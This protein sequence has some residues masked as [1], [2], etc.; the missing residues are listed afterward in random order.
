MEKFCFANGFF[1]L[2]NFSIEVTDTVEG[3]EGALGHLC[4]PIRDTVEEV[5]EGLKIILIVDKFTARNFK[6]LFVTNQVQITLYGYRGESILTQN[7]SLHQQTKTSLKALKVLSKFFVSPLPSNTGP[8]LKMSFLTILTTL[9]QVRTYFLPTN[10]LGAMK[11]RHH[12]TD[13][14]LSQ[15]LN[16]KFNLLSTSAVKYTQ[17]QASGGAE[18]TNWNDVLGSPKANDSA[19]NDQLR[20]LFIKMEATAYDLLFPAIPVEDK[21]KL[22][23]LW[24]QS[25]EGAYNDKVSPKEKK[26]MGMGGPVLQA[27][28]SLQNM[29][30][31]CFWKPASFWTTIIY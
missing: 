22:G 12:I 3:A 23:A 27:W 18:A 24:M 1:H 26:M 9:A 5:E 14:D 2:P 8:V 21:M 30:Q 31:V 28:Q 13:K 20:E 6:S 25:V 29:S 4:R 19:K 10:F 11:Y 15:K 16:F 7:S 17:S